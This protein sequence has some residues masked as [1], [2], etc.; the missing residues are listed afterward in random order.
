M[1]TVLLE[2]ALREF[3]DR[4]SKKEG[5]R[6]FAKRTG[7]NRANLNQAILGGDRDRNITYD[8]I[9]KLAKADGVPLAVIL[10]RVA[11]VAWE[12]ESA[13]LPAD[14]RA[15]QRGPHEMIGPAVAAQLSAK[16]QKKQP[17][18]GR[19]HHPLTPHDVPGPRRG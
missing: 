11:D 6:A 4:A 10:K 7:I 3:F 1:A 17:A 12:M 9:D 18:A 8:Y 19:H 13:D 5:Q 16:N 2:D 14:Q 15:V